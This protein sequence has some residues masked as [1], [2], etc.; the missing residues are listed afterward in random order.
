MLV[1]FSI[2]SFHHLELALT[3]ELVALQ[4]SIEQKMGRNMLQ[5]QRYEML[6]KRLVNGREV[7]ASLGDGQE[8]KV[9]L[10]ADVSGISLGLVKNELLRTFIREVRRPSLTRSLRWIPIRPT[11]LSWLSTFLLLQNCGPVAAKY[12][13]SI[14]MVELTG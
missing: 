5:F 8:F 12:A 14:A 13:T 3:D 1:P 9:S 4:Q 11:W 7:S 10:P 6:M 2:H